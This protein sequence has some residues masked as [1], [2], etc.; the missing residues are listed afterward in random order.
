M[1]RI[2]A[3][4]DAF[5]RLKQESELLQSLQDE[6]PVPRVYAVGD[7]EGR[8]YQ[9]QHFVPGQ[10][11]HSAWKDL[12]PARPRDDLHPPGPIETF[13]SHRPFRLIGIDDEMERDSYTHKTLLS[14]MM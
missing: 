9:L 14:M 2:G 8:A 6:I 12:L 1:I 7:L 3:R 4:E 5:E 11:L 10:K 13:N